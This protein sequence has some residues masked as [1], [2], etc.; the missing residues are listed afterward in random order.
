MLQS[1]IYIFQLAGVIGNIKRNHIRFHQN[2][3]WAEYRIL[4]YYMWIA[5]F[6]SSYRLIKSIYNRKLP[7][8][9]L[10]GVAVTCW[11]EIFCQFLSGISEILYKIIFTIFLQITSLNFASNKNCFCLD[12]VRLERIILFNFKSF[13]G[14]VTIGPFKPLTA[15]IGSNGSEFQRKSNIMDAISFVMGEKS[16]SLRIKQLSDL[17]YGASVGNPIA[18]RCQNSFY[19]LLHVQITVVAHVTAVFIFEDNSKKTFTRA[20]CGTSSEYKINDQVMFNTV[21]AAQFYLSELR[22]LNLNVKAGNFLVF[23][24]GIENIAT[25]TSKEYTSMIEQI[26]NSIEMKEEYERLKSE[27]FKAEE[28]VQFI[29]KKKRDILM[30]KK[31]VL[32]SIEEANHYKMLHK[33]YLD[34]KRELQLFQLFHIEKDIEDLQ[35]TLSTVKLNINEHERDKELAIDLLRQKNKCLKEKLTI[36]ENLEHDITK[37]EN[38]FKQKEGDFA[39]VKG[40]VSY[41]QQQ[42]DTTKLL[43]IE[44]HKSNAAHRKAIK[45]LQ[46]ELL[47]VEHLTSM[48]E[49]NMI[50]Q[51]LSQQSNIEL[52]DAQVQE[53]FRLKVAVE[54][55][56][57]EKIQLCNSLKSEQIVNQNNLDNEIRKKFELQTKLNHKKDEKNKYLIN[58]KHVENIKNELNDKINAKNKLE[59]ALIKQKEE[60]EATQLELQHVSEQLGNAKLDECMISR[61]NK[62]ANT[63]KLLQNLFP[64]VVCFELNHAIYCG[65][66]YNLCKPIHSRYQI[67]M[68]KV[69]GKYCNAIIVSTMNVAKECIHYL[70]E[71]QIGIETF[72]PLDSLKTKPAEERLRSITDPKNVKLL[73]DVL[74]FSPE[75][76]PAILFVT[77]NVLICETLDE[78]RMLTFE[79]NL[80]YIHNCVALDGTYF[81]KGGLISGG[82]VQLSQKAKVWQEQELQELRS[83]KVSYF[84]IS[85]ELTEKL[86]EK[87]SFFRNELEMKALDVEIRGLTSRLKYSKLNLDEAASIRP[88]FRLQQ[89][90]E[91]KLNALLNEID[92]T[93]NE[94]KTVNK[95][96]TSI[97]KLMEEKEHE[98]QIAEKCIQD[99]EDE[100]FKTFCRAIGVDNIRQ[101]EQGNL[102]IHQEQMERKMELEHLYNRIKNQLD[103]EE[104]RDTEKA[105]NLNLPLQFIKKINSL[106]FFF[107]HDLF[108]RL[109]GK[110][111]ILCSLEQHL[112]KKFFQVCAFYQSWRF[113]L[114]QIAKILPLQFIKKIN[115]LRFFFAKL[116]GK[117][118]ILCSLEQHLRKKFF[119][120]CAFY[121][122]WILPLQFIKKINSLRFFF[123][124][125][126][127]YRLQGKDPI[128]CSLE[129]HL[130]KKFFQVCAFY[131]SWRFSIRQIAKILPLQFI[132]KINSLRF[133]FRHD[134]F[135]RLQ[136]KDPILCSLEQ[137][138]RKK[139]FQVCAFYQS[140]R[141]SIRQIAKI[142]PL[143]FIKKINSLGRSKRYVS[144]NGIPEKNSRIFKALRQ[145]IR[146]FFAELSSVKISR[147]LHKTFQCHNFFGAVLKTEKNM[148]SAKQELE[149]ACQEEA[150]RKIII[151]EELDKLNNLRVEYDKVKADVT[152]AEKSVN[153]CRKQI[154]VIERTIV[155]AHKEHSILMTNIRKKIAEHHAIIKN[156]KADKSII[157]NLNY[158]EN[159]P[160]P[161]LYNNSEDVQSS[162]VTTDASV[163]EEQ[164]QPRD[165]LPCIDFSKL[166]QSLKERTEINIDDL[167]SKFT[168]KLE[169][170]QN[171]LKSVENCN[172]KADI[173]VE[174]L[175]EELKEINSEHLRARKKVTTMNREFEVVKKQR[176]DRFIRGLEHINT[177]IDII[178]KSLVKDPSAQAVLL[179]EN[180]EEPYLGG[181]N[182]NCIA[183]GKRFQLMSNF[184]G[185]EKTVAALALLFAIH[186][187]RPAPFL[188]LDEVDAALDNANIK[189]FEEFMRSRIKEIQF[190]IISLKHR[191]FAHTD[192]LIGIC[193]DLSGEYPESLVYTLSLEKY[194]SSRK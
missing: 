55:Q 35:E 101:Y 21:V 63:I 139:F 191:L 79:A 161:L 124:H 62:E 153:H 61:L 80:Q 177:Q 48:F 107:R 135:Y 22:E 23:Q 115:S 39:E 5:I 151:K 91:N 140:W 60:L 92:I 95:N 100:V 50:T 136:G 154:H 170:L 173:E 160:I 72:L 36:M 75:I 18:D 1:D 164:R 16:R 37:M 65:R 149:N 68:T 28:E 20:I 163:N 98:I 157:M 34:T 41:W 3:F 126:L 129:Q 165:A 185:G 174:S 54:L 74:D 42:L 159:I 119:Q 66:L 96:L 90:S 43:S 178:Y 172:L 132:K 134:L 46:N 12:V 94:L 142:L 64:G 47:E 189:N 147:F 88:I 69:F 188:V 113:S 97:K 123:R 33:Q 133:F 121:Q 117:D 171:E 7:E 128:L 110:D 86:R 70:K 73:Y 26:S 15:I 76:N 9:M 32:L 85:M 83:K 155:N 2:I 56:S 105:Y 166:S 146:L 38:A 25:K 103:Y 190:I 106:R 169:K 127:F 150:I 125:D 10:K 141:F 111:P 11:T 58:V 6:E 131:Q 102:R 108:Y 109:Q 14:K 144:V 104:N 156:S 53:Y 84:L 182:Y 116:Q 8:A 192:A 152:E 19:F 51:L 114:R 158:I 89:T 67:A 183:P 130:R 193:S 27:V 59:E 52:N 82:L 186:S 57:S 168:S 71:Q 187:F 175:M 194:P 30:R 29:F 179:A 148:R 87:M 31:F 77:N 181:I 138:L 13:K 78:A 180:P 118:P 49:Q 122:S 120:V 184:S 145:D 81:K 24:G 4:F 162:T 44:A 176:C 40:K 143:Q 112:R 137:H 45:E 167:K 93:A 17:I 99:I